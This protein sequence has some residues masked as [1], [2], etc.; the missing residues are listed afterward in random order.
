M[1][2]RRASA[3]VA[4]RGYRGTIYWDKSVRG[5][6]HGRPVHYNC[7]RACI[8][9]AGV[10]YSYRSR[11]FRECELFLIRKTGELAERVDGKEEAL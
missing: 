9:V 5:A 11:D 8:Q 3:R 7:Y 2:E 1:F 10:R 6:Q 4:A